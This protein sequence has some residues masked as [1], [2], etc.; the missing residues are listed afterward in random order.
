[1]RRVCFEV[2]KSKRI[3]GKATRT[4]KKAKKGD[5]ARGRREERKKRNEKKRALG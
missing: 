3:R 4:M 1:V 2:T 5:A